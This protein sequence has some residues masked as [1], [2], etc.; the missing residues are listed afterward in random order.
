[1]RI[2]L[3]CATRSKLIPHLAYLPCTYTTLPSSFDC[4][5]GVMAEGLLWAI[6]NGD[7]EALKEATAKV[8]TCLEFVTNVFAGRAG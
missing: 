2:R 6:K 7:L 3:Y 1:V 5:V 8:G 4:E